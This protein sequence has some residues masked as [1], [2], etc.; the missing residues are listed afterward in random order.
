MHILWIL[1]KN[2]V[3]FDQLLFPLE[4]ERVRAWH[5]ATMFIFVYALDGLDYAL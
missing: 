1:G 5:C 4:K 2:Y 3:E